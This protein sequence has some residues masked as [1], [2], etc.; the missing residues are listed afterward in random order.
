MRVKADI[1]VGNYIVMVLAS[2]TF[3]IQFLYDSN[4]EYLNGLVLEHWSLTAIFGHMWLHTG[5]VHII[6]NLIVLWVFGR[7]V[8]LRIGNAHYIFAYL[9]VGFASAVVH[10]SY[11]GRPAIGA[12]GA[13][14]GIL[15]IHVVL[16]F[17]RL[18][19]LGP[20]IILVWFLLNLTAGVVSSSA[21]AYLAHVGGFLGGIVLAA[22]LVVL[23]IIRY[24]S[25]A[26]PKRF[27][28]PLAPEQIA[29]N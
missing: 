19:Q 1:P 11:D 21:T 8:C 13:I 22:L 6:Y 16:C 23:K 10:M 14:M 5:L 3:M 26:A 20:W 25:Q 24:D 27:D 12:S 7:Y 9:L 17:D 29:R 15:G 4:H 2:L 28:G 18:S